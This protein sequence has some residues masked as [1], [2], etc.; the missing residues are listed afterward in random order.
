M[1]SSL[2]DGDMGLVVGVGQN[3]GPS[4]DL[5]VFYSCASEELASAGGGL[6]V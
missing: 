2:L 4:A 6:S 5:F 3:C 1:Q